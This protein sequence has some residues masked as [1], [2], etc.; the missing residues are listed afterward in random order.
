MFDIMRH[1]FQYNPH[2]VREH[3]YTRNAE[4]TIRQQ[5][6]QPSNSLYTSI[7]L[8]L[9]RSLSLYAPSPSA[10]IAE[11]HKNQQLCSFAGVEGG[12]SI[13]GSL[14][15]LRMFYALGVRYMTLTSTCHTTWADCSNADAPKF[16]AKHGGLTEHGKVS[17]PP[18]GQ[19]QRT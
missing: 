14:S 19:P 12:H 16:D 8:F 9:C 15:V 2:I 6:T 7:S 13:A 3:K 5:F 17:M 18:V 4:T 11:A 1:H 10:D